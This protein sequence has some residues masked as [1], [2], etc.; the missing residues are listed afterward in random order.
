MKKGTISLSILIILICLSSFLGAQNRSSRIQYIYI[1][2]IRY[3]SVND[4]VDIYGGEFNWNYTLKKAFWEVNEHQIVFSL[5][6]PYVLV[7]GRTYNLGYEVKFKK[8]ALYVPRKNIY[9]VLQKIKEGKTKLEE[10]IQFP[11]LEEKTEIIELKASRK[12]NGILIEILVSQPL[13]YEIFLPGNNWLNVNFFQAKIDTDSFSELKMP[14]LVKD[15]KAFQF[16]NSAQLSLLLSKSYDVF[17]HSLISEPYRIQISME[18]TNSEFTLNHLE[19]IVKRTDLMDVVII[20]PGHGGDDWGYVG[21]NGLLEKEV[22]LDIA[23]RL[24]DLFQGHDDLKVFLTR[25]SDL[26]LPIEQRARFANQNGG[27]IILS[28]HTNFSQDPTESGFQIL[29]QGLAKSEKDSSLQI[30]ESYSPDLDS[31]DKI[32]DTLIHLDTTQIEFIQESKDMALIVQEE[33]NR[34]LPTKDKGIN[35]DDL[36]ILRKAYMPGIVVQIAYISNLTEESLLREE[37]FKQWIAQALYQA[38]LRFQKKSSES[39]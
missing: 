35:Q 33:L 27:D 13:E 29:I 20:D 38:I 1:D 39:L 22:V 36:L 21:S 28:L 2:Q 26:S 12:L 3:I 31:N 23:K 4:L 16:E 14:G 19:R 18:D 32:A 8:G 17:S 30:T 25:E 11:T 5:F 24:K 9:P 7:D 6:S 15:T 37:A 34:I 10:K